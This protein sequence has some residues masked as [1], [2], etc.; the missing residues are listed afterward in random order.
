MAPYLLGLR[1]EGRRVLVVGGGRVAQRR[2]PA[3]LDAGAR[4][5]IV[6][7]SVTPALDDLIAAGRV[8]WVRRPYQV[9]DCDGAWLV[10]AC[11]DRREVNA[12]V[13]AEA[14]AK[15]IWCVRAD[16]REASAAWTPATGRVGEVSVAVTAGGD[17]RRAAG[18][19]DV[20]VGALRDGTI[21][22]RRHRAKPVGVAL[23]GGGPGDPGLI[24][25][26][27]RQL[28][29]QADV[30]IADRLAPRA[31]L[32]ELAPDVELID[33][34]KVPYGRALPQ[35]KINELLVDRA[36]KGK[37]VV[38]LKGGD[39]FVFGRGAE[40][41]L[42][43]ARAGIPVT[44]VPGVTSAVAVPAAAGVPVT[45]RGLAQDFHVISVHVP[46]GDPRS[47]VDWAGLA[48]SKGTL[49]LLMGVERISQVADTL[50]QYGRS[51]DTPVMVVQDGTLP[52]QRSVRATL[53]TVAERVAAVGIR[54]PAVVIVGD[55]VNVGQEIESVRAERV[56]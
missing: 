11:T 22:A 56:P 4:V 9:G 23:V 26:R 14:E 46:P 38:R 55:V 54:P 16:D 13:A 24:T 17:P 19:R 43:C 25:V 18:I 47:T 52:T 48:R 33:A 49:I 1:L 2:V 27:G 44:V 32:D 40:E 37:F 42:A 35:E 8:E 41:L 51:P 34:A 29:A 28:L 6:S 36:R 3:L 10:H 39:P 21:D 20:V 12:A 30:V 5:T 7:P 53:S 45:H 50:R 31:L 15:R